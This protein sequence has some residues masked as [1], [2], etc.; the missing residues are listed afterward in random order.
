MLEKIKK[1]YDMGIYK[2]KHLQK[3][4]TVQAITETEYNTALK[5]DAD[6]E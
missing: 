4:L 2:E 1:Y 6:N 3:L 5:G